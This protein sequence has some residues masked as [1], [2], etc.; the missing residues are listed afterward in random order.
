M[1]GRAEGVLNGAPAGQIGM[2]LPAAVSVTLKGVK[3]AFTQAAAL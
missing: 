3:T 1:V 2:T